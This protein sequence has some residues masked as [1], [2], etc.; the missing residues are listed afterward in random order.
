MATIPKEFPGSASLDETC[1]ALKKAQQ[2]NTANLKTVEGIVNERTDGT[3][4]NLNEATFDE[5]ARS[6]QVLDDLLCIDV[7]TVA[8]AAAAAA[9]RTH[10]KIGP[11]GQS[12]K[13][14]IQDTLTTVQIFA[15]KSPS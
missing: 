6:G 8:G 4:R 13:I 12:F 9:N 10:T 5:V 3:K 2:D 14:W 15:R 1:R 7:S 11:P